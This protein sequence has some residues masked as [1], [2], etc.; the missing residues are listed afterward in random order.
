MRAGLVSRLREMNKIPRTLH[1]LCA[2]RIEASILTTRRMVRLR[3]PE[4]V[5]GIIVRRNIGPRR[6][7]CS[8]ELV[9][10]ALHG[11]SGVDVTARVDAHAVDMAAFHADKDRSVR[12]AYAD[13]GGLVIV[14]LLRD[15]ERAVLAVSAG[16]E[17]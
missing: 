6:S 12:S 7:A 14:L 1:V 15:G 5:R 17:P 4:C 8:H 3:P 9:H 11:Q 10:A 2:N 16:Q 13:I